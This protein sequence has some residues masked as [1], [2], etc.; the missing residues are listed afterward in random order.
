MAFKM[1]S[2]NK[3]SFKMMG[4]SPLKQGPQHDP[5]KTPEATADPEKAKE[6]L[7]KPATTYEKIQST[8]KSVL[9]NPVDIALSVAGPVASTTA[10][11]IEYFTKDKPTT[12]KY[13]PKVTSKPITYPEGKSTQET[14]KHNRGL[15]PVPTTLEGKQPTTIS[16]NVPEPEIVKKQTLTP[17]TTTKKRRKRKSKK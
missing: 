4:S 6:F 10:K 8:I 3:P 13:D 15:T 12:S 11:A 7:D 1:K 2:G 16:H 14:K 17:T 5:K 9:K